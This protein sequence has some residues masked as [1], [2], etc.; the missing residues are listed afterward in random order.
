LATQERPA[1]DDIPG[2]DGTESCS[3]RM[4]ATPRE[5]ERHRSGMPMRISSV[6]T[7]EEV[8]DLEDDAKGG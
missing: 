2:V 7:K 5:S 3:A 8:D 1:P 6:F 4:K